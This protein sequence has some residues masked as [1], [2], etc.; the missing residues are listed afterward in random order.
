MNWTFFYRYA[1]YGIL[2]A[3]VRASP[4]TGSG[5]E[6]INWRVRDY[7]DIGRV[8]DTHYGDGTT[9]H[10]DWGFS[11]AKHKNMR[12]GIEYT[13][14]YN[15]LERMASKTK[16]GT[17]SQADIVKN[18]SYDAQ[19]RKTKRN[20]SADNLT[21]TTSRTYDL[22]GRLTSSTNEA[23]LTTTREYSD[24]GSTVKVTQP[25]GGT[26]VTKRYN[27]GRTKSVTGSAVTD[28]YYEYGVDADGTR[29]TKVYKGEMPDSG[30][31][32][33]IANW[34]KT[35]KD[36]LGRV[37]KTEKPAFDGGTA[38]T[39]RVY[40]DRGQL[41]KSTQPG[42][43]DRLYVY[44][45]VG[46]RVRSGLDVDGD[47]TLDPAETDRINDSATAY[48]KDSDGD[49]WRKSVSKTY[50]T[51]NDSTALTTSVRKRRL[52][53]F[54]NAIPQSVVDRISTNSPEAFSVRDACLT[55][56]SV[57]EDRHGN[58]T[59]SRTYTNPADKTVV[60]VSDTPGSET[61][62]VTVTVN[63]H[64]ELRISAQGH[65]THYDYDALGRRIQVTD[66]RI[67]SYSGSDWENTNITHYNDTV[68][69]TTARTSRATGH[70]TPIMRT[71]GAANGK[72][73]P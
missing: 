2:V 18:V 31:F 4:S 20:H 50:P 27:D 67:S 68:R 35:T 3:M 54:G 60:K 61:P 28:K 40:N 11:G 32:T 17:D 38:V 25:G 53:G 69:W 49:W 70:P 66:P 45:A 29:W 13:Y 43:A 52:T 64:T 71:G 9:H 73:T 5:Y 7:D 39:T 8:I 44:N 26:R 37:V 57:S 12:D 15:A 30:D 10:V 51:D 24:G 21:Q 14:T 65:A 63:G 56:E 6:R 42:K 47:G 23:G 55:S 62:A 72:K 46:E 36:A 19:G 1:C 34:T 22:A 33:D 58:R 48:E 16:L 59:I 41:V